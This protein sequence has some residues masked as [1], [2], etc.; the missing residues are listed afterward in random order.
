MVKMHAH[1]CRY[2][3]VCESRLS[4]PAG[5]FQPS[6]ANQ[7]VYHV[8]LEL[9]RV[10]QINYRKCSRCLVFCAGSKHTFT[11]EKVL[12]SRFMDIKSKSYCILFFHGRRMDR[13]IRIPV[14]QKR[15]LT[16]QV[17]LTP[18]P[19]IFQPRTPHPKGYHACR[20]VNSHRNLPLQVRAETNKAW[21]PADNEN[22][23]NRQ[24]YL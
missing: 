21:R 19:G 8:N 10:C 22:S 4:G 2:G 14:N 5:K 13:Y 24:K 17:I 1:Q 23:M 18:C 16:R 12:L 7:A 11:R 3:L 6:V 9:S 15:M 20:P